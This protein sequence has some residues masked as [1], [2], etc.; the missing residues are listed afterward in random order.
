MEQ[1]LTREA[2][3]PL[4][5]GHSVAVPQRWPIRLAGETALRM[6]IDEA[7]TELSRDL[8]A[9]TRRNSAGVSR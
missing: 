5:Y 3:Q 1:Q 2:L 7:C 4:K 6:S 8:A 9:M